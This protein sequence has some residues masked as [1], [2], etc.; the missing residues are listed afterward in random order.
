MPKNNNADL[1][2]ILKLQKMPP[3]LPGDND[4]FYLKDL[5]NAILNDTAKGLGTYLLGETGVSGWIDFANK[6]KNF[7]NKLNIAALTGKIDQATDVIVK[8]IGESSKSSSKSKGGA[9]DVDIAD[10]PGSNG[11]IN[12]AVS[13]RDAKSFTKIIDALYKIGSK[14]TDGLAKFFDTMNKVSYI[15]LTK[16]KTGFIDPLKD[17][18]NVDID[19]GLETIK[20]ISDPKLSLA[21][22]LNL[23]FSQIKTID[24]FDAT[25]TFDSL[26]AILEGFKSTDISIEK[27]ITI[28]FIY[29]TLT[30][31]VDSIK[32][33][34][35]SLKDVETVSD[36]TIANFYNIAYIGYY[37]DYLADSLKQE[38]ID[39][40]S[41]GITTLTNLFGKDKKDNPFIKI[42]DIIASITPEL[43]K[44][45]DEFIKTVENFSEKTKEFAA[46]MAD[47][48]ANVEQANTSLVTISQTLYE[49]SEKVNDIEDK[50]ANIDF[51]AIGDSLDALSGFMFKAGLLMVIGGWIMV[52]HPELVAGSFKFALKLAIFIAT[53]T[54]PLL[55]VAIVGRIA[56]DGA[57]SIK[58]LSKFIWSMALLMVIG[59][60]IIDGTLGDKIDQNAIKF[61][62]QLTTFI[63]L[64]SIPMVLIGIATRI[65]GEGMADAI[66]KF[67]HFIIAMSAIMLIG[68]VFMSSK[69]GLYAK[70]AINFGITLAK[71]IALVSLPIIAMSLF[72]KNAD[73]LE[74]SLDSFMKV[75][76]ITS[77]IM[78]IG[79]KFISN[80]GG[81]NKK[82]SLQFG[83][84]LTQF[85]T[86]LMVP[87][88][89]F[90]LIAN[91]PNLLANI[92]VFARMV[93][94]M[95]IVL[96]IGALFM[97]IKNGVLARSA[98]VF[99]VI[100]TAFIA[101]IGL[102]L[103]LIFKLAGK[104]SLNI[105]HQFVKLITNLSI[106]LI[107][108]GLLTVLFPGFLEGAIKFG[109]VLVGF[110]ALIGLVLAV[111]T[112][113]AGKNAIEVG[114]NFAN[115]IAILSIAL[116]VGALLSFIPGFLKNAL[117]FAGV[118]V[119]YTAL[120]AII[121]I[122]IGQF[123]G[124]KQIKAVD[125]FV[126]LIAILAISLTIGALLAFI[127]GFLRNALLFAGIMVLYT[128]VMGAIFVGITVFTN[129]KTMASVEG[130]VMLVATLAVSSI[131]GALLL[132]IPGFQENVITFA[133][134]MTIYTA[135]MGLIFV[136]ITRFTNKKNMASVRDFS[137]MVGIL[138]LS[139]II[140]GLML[141]IPGM[142][143]NVIVF[144][145]IMVVY[146]ALMGAVFVLISKTVKK[147]DLAALTTFGIFV[148]ILAGTMFVFGMMA[149]TMSWDEILKMAS[150][151][152]VFVGLMFVVMKLLGSQIST[153]V[154]ATVSLVLMGVAFGLLGGAMLLIAHAMSI[155]TWENLAKFIVMVGL[156]IG[157]LLPFVVPYVMMAVSAAS[158]I[159]M[160]MST[161]FILLGL[162]LSELAS[163]LV[164]ME[165]NNIT[166][167]RFGTVMDF[168]KAV[169]EKM[170]ETFSS[171]GVV[172]LAKVVIKA[173]LVMAALI[174]ITISMMMLASVIK[175][176]ANLKMATGYGPDG[177]PNAFK[178]LTTEDMQKCV[179]NMVE[180]MKTMIR[181][182]Y[183]IYNDPQCQ[184]VIDA[185][186]SGGILARIFGGGDEKG[187]RFMATLRLSMLLSR[188]I[189]SVA[190]NIA[191]L[192]KMMIPDKWDKE[193]NATHYRMITEED[194]KVANRVIK[195]LLSDVAVTIINWG[196][197]HKDWLDDFWSSNNAGRFYRT[198]H[199]TRE[200]SKLVGDVA[201][202]IVK[203][204]NMQVEDSRGKKVQITPEDIARASKHINMLLKIIPGTLAGMT[205][206]ENGVLHESPDKGLEELMEE[207]ATRGN[208]RRTARLQEMI[209]NC[210][211]MIGPLTD[212][213]VKLASL[214]VPLVE[215]G[216]IVEGKFVQ[217]NSQH[218]SDSATNIKQILSW[219]PWAV[220]N[221]CETA[222]KDLK[223]HEDAI[224]KVSE[225]MGN[226]GKMLLDCVNVIQAYADL[227]IP[228]GY[229]AE[230]KPTGYAPMDL[231]KSLSTMATNFQLI[232]GGMGK[233]IASAWA[234]FK[235]SDANLKPEDL[236]EIM[237]GIQPIGDIFAG[238]VGA[239]QNYADLKIP[240]KYNAKGEPIKFLDIND[241]DKLKVYLDKMSTNLN[242]IL[243]GMC[244]AIVTATNSGNLKTALVEM[245]EAGL[246]SIVGDITTVV[247]SVIE[248]LKNLSEL[249][250]P[251]GDLDKDGKAKSYMSV[252]SDEFESK[253]TKALTSIITMMP[254]AVIAA[255][256]EFSRLVSTNNA[257]DYLTVVE[258]FFED[259]N[260]ID[261]TIVLGV[262]NLVN[263]IK[264]F[265]S[266]KIPKKFNKKGE[267][268]EYYTFTPDDF[269]SIS[270]T[271]RLILTA[272]PKAMQ[273]QTIVDIINGTKINTEQMTDIANRSI[274]IM[275]IAVSIVKAFK[276]IANELYNFKATEIYSTVEPIMVGT[277]KLNL[278]IIEEYKKFFNGEEVDPQ[279]LGNIIRVLTELISIQLPLIALNERLVEDIP[280]LG[281]VVNSTLTIN[282]ILDKL[283]IKKVYEKIDKA[284]DVSKLDLNEIKSHVNEGMLGLREIM[285]TAVNPQIEV[286]GGIGA[287]IISKFSHKND[288]KEFE[289][290][291]AKLTAYSEIML[292]TTNNL[293]TIN[294]IGSELDFFSFLE[295]YHDMDFLK[296]AFLNYSM[297]D[298]QLE[299]VQDTNV[300][301]DKFVKTIESVNVSKI[302]PMV[303]LIDKLIVLSDKMGSI[304]KFTNVLANQVTES[305]VYLGN[306][307]NE[308]KKLIEET[309]IEKAN[310]E[311]S[312][313]DAIKQIDNLMSQPL[314]VNVSSGSDDKLSASYE[315]PKD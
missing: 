238:V 51:K 206:D 311:K 110:V 173:N 133:L 191:D 126:R 136:A 87:L 304:D 200:L 273:D 221:G 146:T 101:V 166:P 223:G 131:I 13:A 120:M 262:S 196:E 282:G 31:S 174:P 108:G 69:G 281:E 257:S 128:L 263:K 279:K 197:E 295:I 233:G 18:E 286:E 219:I 152:I 178:Q 211:K 218:I 268:T 179:T 34:V 85:I 307:I 111:V 64:L 298:E 203:V 56:D 222:V 21:A 47:S 289:E 151:L 27:A 94:L 240:I 169:V 209:D 213:I 14:E 313:G 89:L 4:N 283:D 242:D 116:I 157:I 1:A 41:K 93:V 57:E 97:N 165:K 224:K 180:I 123:I 207:F 118:M 187:Q 8:T 220:A 229:D 141:L 98:V 100:L 241:P 249:K 170:D 92:E 172:T 12:F 29:E 19:K 39:N 55:M 250:I 309:N 127:P 37:I 104:D 176:I 84:A 105:T 36:E 252:N 259:L 270:E 52:A 66:S 49:T 113:L 112:R 235:T 26:K 227:R 269:D 76:A 88:L 185:F 192:A 6:A 175:D 155:M 310:R 81:V 237:D 232:L 40:I 10:V 43:Q 150:M 292:N 303:N 65:G 95:T 109:L 42:N 215:N 115:L 306:E 300:E 251:I 77:I 272:I 86:I 68:G 33:F 48:K 253:L 193:G 189:G 302:K 143:E 226:I 99:G 195:S 234:A 9:K 142:R 96:M 70:G 247:K 245:N 276:K 15:D 290:N 181:G 20:K 194:I 129:A 243:V 135:L 121:F 71:F 190:R 301:I 119:L 231:T 248:A 314:H 79:A 130:F 264:G 91:D 7:N 271:I 182:I 280:V 38:N 266:F 61:A 261:N 80:K 260:T 297:D 67:N 265:T 188:V 199:I 228:T 171:I 122:A 254:K 32:P 22:D 2:E 239:L 74:K 132:Y 204:A 205:M 212:T 256:N 177:K 138:A 82:Y 144:A 236:K 46:I 163:V 202:N 210:M 208:R 25:P 153:V 216:K 11:T 246:V 183:E 159:L 278:S 44:N 158:G 78:M 30:K 114:E 63:T 73:T 35:T 17:I 134:I 107:V 285:Q 106:A 293:K 149:K 90:K 244:N 305:I 258:D 62:I 24:V 230:G 225:S 45:V 164:Y 299:R 140:G 148:A 162:A 54:I 201:D 167:A 161:A 137:I 291:L 287:K 147:K 275:E 124:D 186:N 83:L 125:N 184:E 75:V 156:M 198:I 16:F 277:A 214:Q 3:Q 217:L 50:L 308:A 315:R 255:K 53:L 58:V 284:F 296:N 139:A 5:T 312:I 160:L 288:T 145:T 23:L 103:A 154:K 117:L 102:A 267:A 168:L 274:D 60:W 28:G 72:I 59:S 294:E